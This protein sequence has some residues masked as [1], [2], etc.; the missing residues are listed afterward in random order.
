M[1]PEES[2]EQAKQIEWMKQE[3]AKRYEWAKHYR[4]R[5]MQDGLNRLRQKGKK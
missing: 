2:F 1:T 3:Q 4:M 5:I